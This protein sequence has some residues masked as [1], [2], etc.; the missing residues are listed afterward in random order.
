MEKKETFL[1]WELEKAKTLGE[2]ELEKERLQL[3]R[4]VNDVKIMLADETLLDEHA[5]KWLV[6][7]KKEINEGREHEAARV[8]MATEEGEA[9][10]QAEHVPSM[11]AEQE[12][13]ISF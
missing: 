8:A 11:H 6:G 4:D 3:A 10:M 7:I 1:K 9:R 13:L 2:I 12:T 5:K